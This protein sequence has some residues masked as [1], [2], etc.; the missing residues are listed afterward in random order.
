MGVR[1][2]V[3]IRVMPFNDAVAIRVMCQVQGEMLPGATR[4][5]EPV[6][7]GPLKNI[8]V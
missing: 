7:R 4:A 5:E 6:E 3:A 2:R 1:G 8:C